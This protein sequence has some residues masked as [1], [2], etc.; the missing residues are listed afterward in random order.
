[1]RLLTSLFLILV[2]TTFHGQDVPPGKVPAVAPDTPQAVAAS[3]DVPAGSLAPDLHP[4]D[5]VRLDGSLFPQLVHS[6]GIIFAGRV[7]SV[8]DSS[9]LSQKSHASRVT[10][11]VEHAIRGTS[12]GQRLTI[13]QW[14][15]LW[16]KTSPYF[17]GEHVLLFL[18]NPG[19]LGLTSLVAG[20]LGAFAI[21]SQGSVVLSSQQVAAFAADPILGGAAVVPYRDFALAVR[22]S[23]G[24]EWR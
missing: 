5:P 12:S 20:A 10:F 4:H 9:T 7:I 8:G 19:K 21:D 13:H 2:A 11:E 1:M 14:S 24:E 3:H 16:A 23:A 18:Y 15:G 6:A 17:V 22:R